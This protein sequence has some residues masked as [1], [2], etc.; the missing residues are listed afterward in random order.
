MFS[1]V[2]LDLKQ[3]EGHNQIFS[4]LLKAIWKHLLTWVPMAFATPSGAVP[5]LCYG[6]IKGLKTHLIGWLV[7]W[8][9]L[10][11]KRRLFLIGKVEQKTSG[12]ETL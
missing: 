7:G 12:P 3:C 4:F 1:L 5:F 11:G 6:K 10:A 2:F 9:L 8:F